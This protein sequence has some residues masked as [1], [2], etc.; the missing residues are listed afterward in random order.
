M[1]PNL[2]TAVGVLGNILVVVSYL[3]QIRKIIVTKKSDDLS[4]GMWGLYVLGDILLLVYAAATGDTIFTAL[5][6]LFTI[7]NLVVLY[8]AFKYAKVKPQ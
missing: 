7:E 1:N 3:P 2:L 4:L 5:F 8:L 6:T